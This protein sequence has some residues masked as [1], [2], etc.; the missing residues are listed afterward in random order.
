MPY[1]IPNILKEDWDALVG[2]TDYDRNGGVSLIDP[3]G[4]L[5]LD[6]RALTVDGKAHRQK[7]FGTIGTGNYYSEIRLKSDVWDGGGE[8]TNDGMN[9]FTGGE[10]NSLYVRIAN[11]CSDG[12]GV[13]VFDGS[14]WNKVLVKTWDNNWHTI[15]FYVHNNQT[16]VDIWIDKDPSETADVIDADCSWYYATADGQAGVE[17][18]GSEAGEGEYHQD[19]LYVGT[20]LVVGPANVKSVNGVAIASVKS[21]NSVAIAD[22]KSINTIT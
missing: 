2:W 16:D 8:D 18:Y 13:W 4:Q 11:G 17:A 22:I 14:S 3:A 1:I 9:H 6:L 15:V 7:V 5:Y 12:D 21:I 20:G 19:Y 10:T